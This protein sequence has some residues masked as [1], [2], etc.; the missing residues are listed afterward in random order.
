L[1]I[2]EVLALKA[3]LNDDFEQDGH[4]VR[5]DSRQIAQEVAKYNS[6]ELADLLAAIS[7]KGQLVE[8]IKQAGQAEFL[9][10]VLL[11]QKN[12]DTVE[13]LQKVA[14]DPNSIEEDFR[15]ILRDNPWMFGGQFVGIEATRQFTTLDQLDIVLVTGNGSIHVVEL[16]KANIPRLVREHRNHYIVGNDVHEAVAQTENYLESLDGEAHTI[17]S[18]MGFEARR[19]FAT[20]VIGHI[21]HNRG[22]VPEEDFYR[23]L[24]IY[25]SHLS[26]IEVLTYDQLIDNAFNS[27]K[28]MVGQVEGGE[29][30][31]DA[32]DDDH[33]E[34]DDFEPYGWEPDGE[35][36]DYQHG[37]DEPAF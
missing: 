12:I 2:K 30:V 27:L 19:A 7:D 4:Y 28:L 15:R 34:P 23:T 21:K 20:V 1:R 13:S 32:D 33:D 18:K 17:K 16:K 24:R 36:F 8:A 10:G 11:G 25:N 37:D 14:E 5:V 35:P 26:R 29:Q 9:T 6:E 22:D 31:G 3:F